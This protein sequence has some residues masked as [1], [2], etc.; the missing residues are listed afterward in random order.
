MRGAAANKKEKGTVS[1]GCR[2]CHSSD[3]FSVNIWYDDLGLEKEQKR[4]ANA[5]VILGCSMALRYNCTVKRPKY[6]TD[7]SACSLEEGRIQY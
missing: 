7:L 5:I 2:R 3:F 4:L 1:C 6:Y